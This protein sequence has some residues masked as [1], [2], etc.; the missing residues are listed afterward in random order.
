M[1]RQS[2]KRKSRLKLFEK[3]YG[4]CFYCNKPMFEECKH[5]IEYFHSIFNRTSKKDLN[6]GKV[7]FYRK[8]LRCSIEH[9]NESRD[10]GDYSKENIVASHHKCNSSRQALTWRQHKK[11]KGNKIDLFKDYQWC[12]GVYTDSC[13]YAKRITAENKVNYKNLLIK[14]LKE[15]EKNV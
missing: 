14:L 15:R 10:G 9:L 3:Q 1:P 13:T 4:L 7:K 2:F 11:N 8:Y 12:K 6:L 5:T